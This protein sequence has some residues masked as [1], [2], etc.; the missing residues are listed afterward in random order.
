MHVQLHPSLLQSCAPDH[1]LVTLHVAAP[2]NVTLL[3]SKSAHARVTLP[4]AVHAALCDLLV[5]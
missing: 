4:V 1:I 3:V 5:I 2:A